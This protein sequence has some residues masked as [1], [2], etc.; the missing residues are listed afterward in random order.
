M[1]PAPTAI[2]QLPRNGNHPRTG[3]AISPDAGEKTASTLLWS[4]K[5]I[6]LSSTFLLY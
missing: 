1:P 3:A 5:E 2:N 6:H 4:A